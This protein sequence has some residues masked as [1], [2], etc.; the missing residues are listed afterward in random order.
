MTTVPLKRSTSRRP[1]PLDRDAGTQGA[2]AAGDTSAISSGRLY[3]GGGTPLQQACG[4]TATA[5]GTFE[6]LMAACGPG[7]DAGKTRHC[8]DNSVLHYN[9]LVNHDAIVY[10]LVDEDFYEPNWIGLRVTWASETLDELAKELDV[11]AVNLIST[12]ERFNRDAAR[13]VDSEFHKRSELEQPF[14]GPIGA[15]VV[16]DSP[17]RW[18]AQRRRRDCCIRVIAT[19]GATEWKRSSP[20]CSERTSD[21]RR[22]GRA[23]G[24]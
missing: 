17:L 1:S 5:N 9:W 2:C 18:S 19:A 24:I 3:L 12:V 13:G 14:V 21:M 10:L 22:F 20:K 4:F 15:V 11:P 6:F 23:G 16:W 7:V 8:C